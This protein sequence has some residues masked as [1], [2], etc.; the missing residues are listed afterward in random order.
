MEETVN[1]TLDK[2]IGEDDKKELVYV[3]ED[4]AKLFGYT[5]TDLNK[6]CDN[7]ERQNKLL[8]VLVAL[9]LIIV[10]MGLVFGYWLH[11]HDYLTR[12]LEAI[13]A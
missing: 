12:L 7:Q 8:F 6:L 5:Q 13:L 3:Q 2:S 11:S 4:G 10:G 1:L 9:L